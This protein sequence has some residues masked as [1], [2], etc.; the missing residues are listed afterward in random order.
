[1]DLLGV[2]SNRLNCIPLWPAVT[3]S[4]RRAASRK[5]LHLTFR[6]LRYSLLGDQIARSRFHRTAFLSSCIASKSCSEGVCQ[7]GG[8]GTRPYNRSPGNWSRRSYLSEAEKGGK[9]RLLPLTPDFAEWV[10]KTPKEQR[11]SLVFGL[12]LNGQPMA[13]ATVSKLVAKFTRRPT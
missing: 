5:I 4:S 1:M 6:S 8:H 13:P 10:L 11:R 3:W 7:S 2:A 9:D 12:E